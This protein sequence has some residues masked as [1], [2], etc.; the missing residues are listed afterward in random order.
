MSDLSNRIP[1]TTLAQVEQLDRDHHGDM[2][3][4]Y[5]D[6]FN[7]RLWLESDPSPAYEHGRRNGINDRAGTVDADQAGIAREYVAR[8]RL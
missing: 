3:K 6:G 8:S 7:G 2:V 1:V 5:P 4:G